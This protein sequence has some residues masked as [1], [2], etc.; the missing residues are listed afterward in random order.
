MHIT[1][2]QCHDVIVCDR[3]HLLLNFGW[4]LG[5]DFRCCMGFSIMLVFSRV[6]K[7]FSYCS[8]HSLKINKLVQYLSFAS[9]LYISGLCGPQ[10]KNSCFVLCL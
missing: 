3:H 2:L 6:N 8:E 4:K 5:F 1:D 10:I 7:V 9:V